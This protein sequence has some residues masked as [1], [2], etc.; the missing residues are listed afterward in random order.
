[1]CSLFPDTKVVIDHVAGIRVRD[2]RFPADHV[3]SLCRLARH[4]NVTVKLGP[5]HVLS[6][7]PPPFLDLLPCSAASSTPSAPTAACGRPTSA[8]P[9]R[10]PTPKRSTPPRS[11]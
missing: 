8:A 9:S 10:C 1:M 6:D 3:E 4:P 5:F 2:G 7:Q 11:S